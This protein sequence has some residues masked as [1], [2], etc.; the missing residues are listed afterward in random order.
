[1]NDAV[2]L[3]RT[4]H[5]ILPERWSGGLAPSA[6]EHYAALMHAALHA[7]AARLR[8][9]CCCPSPDHSQDHD[10][11]GRM[12]R[13]YSATYPYEMTWYRSWQT[14]E[15]PCAVLAVHGGHRFDAWL[16]Q[17]WLLMMAAAPLRVS[18]A[19]TATADDQTTW[20]PLL[21]S[22][23]EESGWPA[24][25]SQDVV[26]LGHAGMGPRD[27]RVLY[28]GPDLPTWVDLGP[29]HEARARLNT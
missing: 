15:L 22:I 6:P 23:A 29:L 9:S 21:R 11:Y 5:D 19:F 10:P 3:L 27:M 16:Q 8:L 12:P 28:R 4:L 24:P 18:C 26:L 2:A 7:T 13:G 17:H 14:W 1:M 25:T 20:C